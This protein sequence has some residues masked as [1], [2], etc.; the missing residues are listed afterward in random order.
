[1]SEYRWHGGPLQV[2]VLSCSWEGRTTYIG[3]R[4]IV[5]YWAQVDDCRDAQKPIAACPHEHR[6]VEAA[7]R[8]KNLLIRRAQRALK[9][10]PQGSPDAF[11]RLIKTGS[12]AFSQKRD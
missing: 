2:A 11:R 4:M 5:R 10:S 1:M 6:S 12:A 9:L 8:C 3:Q 7:L